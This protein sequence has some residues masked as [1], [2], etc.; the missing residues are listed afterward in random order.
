M[1]PPYKI[2]QLI[3][4][5]AIIPD[6]LAK[7]HL[8]KNI[9]L[10]S[11]RL[12]EIINLLIEQE[13]LDFSHYKATTISRRI[14]RRRLINNLED[15]DDYIKL[16]RNSHQ[17]RKNLGSDLLINVTHFFRDI[18]AWENLKNNVLPLLIE[19]AQSQEELSFG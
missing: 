3:Y 2:A 17:E 7:A 10:D 15:V 16:L 9:W 19:Q 5:C 18:S 14:E 1:L 8:G 11:S 12:K 6:D 4:Q 13:N